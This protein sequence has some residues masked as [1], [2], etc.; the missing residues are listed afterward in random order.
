M[1]VDLCKNLVFRSLVSFPQVQPTSASGRASILN[2]G[3]RKVIHAKQRCTSLH[4]YQNKGVQSYSHA[5]LLRNETGTTRGAGPAEC[6]H[7]HAPLPKRRN[8][9]KPSC[10]KVSWSSWRVAAE[11]RH[12]AAP[13]AP[14]RV[15]AEAS[16]QTTCWVNKS[17]CL[18]RQE[19]QLR[20]GANSESIST[21]SDRNAAESSRCPPRSDR[22]PVRVK[23]AEYNRVFAEWSGGS[24]S[25]SLAPSRPG[26]SAFSGLC[27]QFHNPRPRIAISAH[28]ACR[29]AASG[30][31][32][33]F[34]ACRR[35]HLACG[36]KDRD[37]FW[38]KK[39]RK[40]KGLGPRYV[41]SFVVFCLECV[42]G[43][44][45]SCPLWSLPPRLIRHRNFNWSH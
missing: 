26:P 8:G 41:L 5:E 16:E 9:F 32:P 3:F 23:M 7:T 18:R 1:C 34:H 27:C 6:L 40:E 21:S 25:A 22:D 43:Y 24:L 19:W 37:P 11:W 45:A 35:P 33:V 38:I 12:R 10:R 17:G 36:R 31:L 13:R 4:H 29:G 2:R 30:R 20:R 44:V 28:W 39:K 42:S 14:T 15:V